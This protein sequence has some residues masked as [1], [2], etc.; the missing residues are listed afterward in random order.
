MFGIAVVVVVAAT[1]LW[2]YLDATKHKIGKITGAGGMFNMSAGAWAVVTL[3][4]WIIAFPA[5]LINRGSLIAKAK[6][7][8]IEVSG[9]EGKA[10]AIGLTGGAWV[11]ATAFLVMSGT[12]PACDSPEVIS[13]AEKIVRDAPLVKLTGLSVKGISMPA[14][15][16]YDIEQEVRTCRGILTHAAGEEA[17]QYTVEWHDQKKGLIWVN[18]LPSSQGETS[19]AGISVPTPPVLA[20]SSQSPIQSTGQNQL[21]ACVMNKVAAFRRERGEEALVRQ[22]MLEE[23]EGECASTSK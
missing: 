20:P 2:V 3:F 16:K 19:P 1:A 8:P 13:L 17:I 15:R 22:D 6:E 5:Y 21:E 10:V 11:A 14:E 4:L 7:T 9:R 12:L 23:W 18:I